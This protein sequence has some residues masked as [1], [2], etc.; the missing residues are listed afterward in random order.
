M[1]EAYYYSESENIPKFIE[2]Y[3]N[4][5]ELLIKNPNTSVY[6]N[7][8]HSGL[9]ADITTLLRKSVNHYNQT[10]IMKNVYNM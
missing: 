8:S 1:F 3:Y 5:V 4:P 6:N 9:F 2:E 10:E 7:P